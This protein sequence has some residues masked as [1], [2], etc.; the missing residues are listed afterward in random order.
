MQGDGEDAEVT[1]EDQQNINT[2]GRL[3]NRLHDLDDEIKTKKVLSVYI[4]SA[5]CVTQY[6]LTD[7]AKEREI[8]HFW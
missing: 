3:N 8:S 7:V 1:W 6:G 5:S 2:F 4:A